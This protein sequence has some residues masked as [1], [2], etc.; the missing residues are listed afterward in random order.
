VLGSAGGGA[1]A[2][3]LIRELD[4][5]DFVR[6]CLEHAVQLRLLAALGGGLQL[7]GA[8]L[9]DTGKRHGGFNVR[10]NDGFVLLDHKWQLVVK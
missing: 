6:G 3:R 2:K 8:L 7:G 9:Q 5:R 4:E 10:G 1:A